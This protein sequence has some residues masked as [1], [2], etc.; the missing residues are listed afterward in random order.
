MCD[1]NANARARTNAR[2][3]ANARKARYAGAVEG[4]VFLGEFAKGFVI[5]DHMD[6]SPP[7]NRISENDHLP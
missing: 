1:A 6:S 7:N 2:S 5:L 3:D 4:C